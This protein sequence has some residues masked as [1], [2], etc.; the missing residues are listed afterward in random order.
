MAVAVAIV[1]AAV[2]GFAAA[3]QAGFL[4]NTFL[5]LVSVRAGRPITVDGALRIELLSWTPS[6]TAERV[7]IGNPH[8]MPPGRMAEIGT[9]SL[10]FEV[11]RRH[12]RFGVDSLSMNSASLH[13]VR[14][15]LGRAN[16]Q[17]SDPTLP[18]ANTKLAIV[19]SL[20]V[21]HAHVTLEDDRRHL[22]FDGIA[23]AEGPPAGAQ[24]R[25][26][27][28]G[29]LNG[30][31][32]SFE[33]KGDS[34]ASASHQRPY[35]FSYTE[36][37]SGS[38]LEGEGVL[39][40]PFDFNAL[41]STFQAGGED[42]QDLY[43]LVGVHMIN[44]GAYRLTGKLE[45][46]ALHFNFSDL[47]VHSGQSDLRGSIGIDS[48]RARPQL[49]VRLESHLLKIADIG[50]RAAG[51]APP[52][53][54]P[55]LLLSK[56][57]LSP[58]GFRPDDATIVLHID[59]VELTR[60]KLQDVAAKGS[61]DHGV[62]TVQSMSGRLLGGEAQGRGKLDVNEDPPLADVDLKLTGLELGQMR[63]KE[64]DSTPGAP[65]P[66]E[67][68]LRARIV[69]SGR[70]SSLHQVAATANGFVTVVVPHGTVRDSLAELAGMDLRALGLLMSKDT[71]DTA[72]R[73]AIA[74]FKDHDGTLTAQDIVADTEPVLI[75]GS[76]QIQF[77]TETLDL[78]LQGEP[79]ELR[80]F[81]WRSPVLIKG[82][83]SHPA[84]DI[85]A[86]KFELVDT[87]KA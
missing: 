7:V 14:D 16:W 24:V 5:H 27:G 62:L 42:L 59:Q 79:K 77:D 2:A 13:L 85:H 66:I 47:S 20:T 71:R 83:L 78:T 52:E 25:I 8:W 10:V 55:P 82:T 11:P 57:A 63:R 51:R 17:W 32:A 81:H 12:H 64:G 19:R 70:G 61:L 35:H 21:P 67:G 26:W 75:T 65:P 50:L 18:Y 37:S 80:L 87:G 46:D 3:V 48:S 73:C 30:H 6:I 72:L 84:I 54:A 9:L 22:K 33:I 56:A 40:R 34:L 74:V 15:A 60:L 44:T 29:D 31:P 53:S 43:Y 58:G 49:D 45:R 76:G 1:V 36:H 28:E 38:H 86:R 23:S 4:R 41:E 68:T 39:P 69:V